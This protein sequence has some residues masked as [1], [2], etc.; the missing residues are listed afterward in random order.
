MLERFKQ[1]LNFKHSRFLCSVLAH[2]SQ[3]FLEN[4]TSI[5]PPIIA[6]TP[7]FCDKKLCTHLR[8]LLIAVEL[9]ERDDIIVHVCVACGHKA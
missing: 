5:S 8:H 4:S 7:N 3:H 2:R 6:T 9:L 1:W